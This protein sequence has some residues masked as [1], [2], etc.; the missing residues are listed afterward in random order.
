MQGKM[1][2][3]MLV[4]FKFDTNGL[5]YSKRILFLLS[6]NYFITVSILAFAVRLA[7][8]SI[9]LVSKSTRLA[10]YSSDSVSQIVLIRFCILFVFQ[11]VNKW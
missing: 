6:W 2:F 1:I 3:V 9:F 4:P 5:T 7:V 10:S 11:T 8:F